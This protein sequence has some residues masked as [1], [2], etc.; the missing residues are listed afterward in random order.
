MANSSDSDTLVLDDSIENEEDLI[1]FYFNDGF[2]Y[3]EIRLFLSK[4]H[5][6]VLSE[7][8]LKRRLKTMGLSRHNT[9]YN[10][11]QVRQYVRGM[12]DGPRSL[13][14]YRSVWHSLQRRGIR[15][16]RSHVMLLLREL[17]PDGVKERAAHKLKRREYHNIG[18]CFSWHC[19]SYDK[20][21]PYGFPI[22]G[23]IDG[24]SR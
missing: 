4:Y 13:G 16:P 15:L 23:C 8:T 21:K 7:R 2:T 22:H 24:W 14:G 19:D 10:M 17:D 12:L 1:N 3:K 6:I 18:P 5:G 11:P 9:Q 20:L